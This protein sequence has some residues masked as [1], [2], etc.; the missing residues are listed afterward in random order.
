MV[1]SFTKDVDTHEALNKFLL[2]KW[3]K[4][5]DVITVYWLI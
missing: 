2:G 5:T 3:Q 4:D 1:E